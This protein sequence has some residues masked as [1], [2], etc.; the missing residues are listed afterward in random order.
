MDLGL[1]GRRALVTGA[2][3]GIGK[4]VA[5]ALAEA[6][7]RVCIA[8]R[9]AERLSAVVAAM[10]GEEAGHRAL[11]IDLMAAQAPAMVAEAAGEA[12]IIV[13]N[14][15]GSLGERDPL[16]G[17][18]SFA[19]VWRFNVGIAI[20]INALL[21]PAMAARGWGRIVHVSTRASIDMRGAAAYSAAKA[22][23]NAYTVSL[24]RA[25]APRGVIVSAVLPGA[26]ATEDNNWGKARVDNPARVAAFLAEHQ[27]IGR[28]GSVEDVVPFVV[29]LASERNRFA[30][31]ALVPVDGG[32][33]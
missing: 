9:R 4:A 20:D 28:L 21:A 14:L 15:G 2:S 19:R 24:G 31:G 30:A 12:D 29:F 22:Y 8:A 23:L 10:G 16:A 32:A 3:A 27:A 11:A 7:C 6:G 25:L 18:D 13:H 26:V 5:L 17:A 33:M 1:R